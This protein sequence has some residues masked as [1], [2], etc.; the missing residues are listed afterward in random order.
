MVFYFQ[1][2]TNWPWMQTFFLE[3]VYMINTLQPVKGY[4]QLYEMFNIHCSYKTYASES[5]GQWLG[6]VRPMFH[7]VYKKMWSEIYMNKTFMYSM[8]FS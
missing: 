1:D 5:Q 8:R 2:N 4:I 7:T 3:R 6:L